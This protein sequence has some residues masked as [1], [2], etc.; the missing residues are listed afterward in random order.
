MTVYRLGVPGCGSGGV[1]AGFLLGLCANQ[2]MI[3][4]PRKSPA[5]SRAVLLNP[6]P[7]ALAH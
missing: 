2:L 7:N 3:F 6:E 1:G 5:K 4:L